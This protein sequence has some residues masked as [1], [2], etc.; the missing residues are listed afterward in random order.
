MIT[1]TIIIVI[2]TDNDNDDTNNTDSNNTKVYGQSFSFSITFVLLEEVQT[3]CH[4][5]LPW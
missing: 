1:N 2:I 5:R 3:E 4:N